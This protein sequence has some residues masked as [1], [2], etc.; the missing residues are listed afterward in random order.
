LNLQQLKVLPRLRTLWLNGIK[1]YGGYHGVQELTQLRELSLS[2]CN[3]GETE[4][5]ALEKALPQT[6]VTV[7]SSGTAYSTSRVPASVNRK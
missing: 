1:Q 4:W 6:Y 7:S 5:H 3:L 2:M